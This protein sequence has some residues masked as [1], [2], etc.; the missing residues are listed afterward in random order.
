M[1]AILY[2]ILSLVVF[3][4]QSQSFTLQ[5]VNQERV[6]VEG[7]YVL[8][9]KKVFLYSDN[10]GNVN[11]PDGFNLSDSVL[12]SHLSYKKIITSIEGLKKASSNTIV[13]ESEI[14]ELNEVTV[15]NLNPK[16]YV[17]NSI[18]RITQNYPHSFN[19]P[20][21][22][23]ADVVF[24]DSDNNS[25]IITYKGGLKLSQNKKELYVGKHRFNQ[26][27]ADNADRYIFKLKPYNFVSIIPISSHPVIKKYK[28]FSF[29]R[30]EY[31]IYKNQ[32]AV[33]IYFQIDRK[34]GGQSGF[35]IINSQDKGIMS[36]SYRINPI[37][38]WIG[39]K[40]KKG[41]VKTSLLAYYVESD[42]EKNETGGY[43]FSSGR[44][45][46][47][48]STKAGKN[49]INTTSDTYLKTVQDNFK[50]EN[51]VILKDIF[52]K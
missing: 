37:K 9:N 34:H 26:Y 1:K 31:V 47:K 46:I 20:L 50:I 25:K 5:I 32:Q 48:I 24:S 51:S 36:L 28:E 2:I 23:H 19:P 39:E 44:E 10:Q 12:I 45:N 49:I 41:I 30:Y 3:Q 15:S 4:A 22:L 33:K 52:R 18:K 38:D 13:L 29:P 14:T 42:Y 21:T 40:T 16:K 7:V 35:L 6:P 11:I 17:E 27:I 43:V 8:L